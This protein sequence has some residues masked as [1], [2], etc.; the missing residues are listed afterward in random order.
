MKNLIC[1]NPRDVMKGD[2]SCEFFAFFVI[3]AAYAKVA[4][5]VD[6]LS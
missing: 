6:A 1:V 3:M 5:L 2:S 4:K